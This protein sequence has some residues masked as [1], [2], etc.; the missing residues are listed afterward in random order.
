[1]NLFAQQFSEK[2][3][4]LSEPLHGTTSFISWNMT[5]KKSIFNANVVN[6]L[7]CQFDISIYALIWRNNIPFSKCIDYAFC[8]KIPLF[9]WNFFANY[10]SNDTIGLHRGTK[11]EVG[12]KLLWSR[13]IFPSI[14]FHELFPDFFFSHFG[15]FAG[16]KSLWSKKCENIYN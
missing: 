16:I 13:I 7:P 1:M 14:Y 15:L 5:K 9:F 6:K 8:P 4:I 12:P 3:R 2:R 11:Y 10:Y